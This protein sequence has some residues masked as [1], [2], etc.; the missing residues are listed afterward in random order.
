MKSFIPYE[1]GVTEVWATALDIKPNNIKRLH[2]LL[3]NQDADLITKVSKHYIEH[4]IPLPVQHENLYWI[5]S[6]FPS[7]DNALIRISIWF[8]E[9]FNI[10]QASLYYGYGQDLQCMVFMHADY[11]TATLKEEMDRQSPGVF[12]VPEYRF[13]TGIKEQLAVFMPLSSYLSFV[14]NDTVYEAICAHNYELTQKGKTPFKKGHNY[15]LVRYLFD[16]T[17]PQEG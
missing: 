1:F 2:R 7:T 14:S 16:R 11:F 9:V 13:S 15:E 4:F 5:I 6:C 3:K 17:L 10:T 12:Y 8:P